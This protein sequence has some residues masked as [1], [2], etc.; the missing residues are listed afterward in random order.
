[1]AS[2]IN[3]PLCNIPSDVSIQL[4]IVNNQWNGA[5]NKLIETSLR[6]IDYPN[7]EKREM[8]Q[9]NLNKSSFLDKIMH[10]YNITIKRNR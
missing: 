3:T 6:P 5:V 9:I 8:K 7:V 1:M 4:T 10:N 2:S